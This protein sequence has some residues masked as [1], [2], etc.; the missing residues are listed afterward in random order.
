MVS[1]Q[2][3]SHTSKGGDVENGVFTAKGKK[4]ERKCPTKRVNKTPPRTIGFP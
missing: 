3:N 2:C 1:R 4:K